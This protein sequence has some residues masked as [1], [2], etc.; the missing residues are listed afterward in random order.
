MYKGTRMEQLARSGVADYLIIA[1]P[2]NMI[3]ADEMP[4]NW[5]VWYIMP[6]K[7]IREVKTP[8]KQQ[9]S[10]LNRLHLMQN[11]GHAALN[12]VL[13]ANGVK[14]TQNGAVR[15]TRQPRARRK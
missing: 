13:F 10:E 6:D 5:G 15:F 4:D 14:I 8:E 2:E 7:S 1:V 12:S 11:I 9:C 3:S